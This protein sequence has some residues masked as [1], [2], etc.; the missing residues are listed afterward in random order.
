MAQLDG[1]LD[2]AKRGLTTSVG[3]AVLV[4]QEAQV[5]RR[6]LSKA[7]PQLMTEVGDRVKML[8][9]KLADIDE[10]S[11]DIFDDVEQRLPDGMRPAAREVHAV[12]REVRTQ[13]GTITGW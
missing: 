4:V 3:V 6:A 9:E 8:G 1:I 2:V 10:R 11:D 12:L 13:V 7:A 5:Q